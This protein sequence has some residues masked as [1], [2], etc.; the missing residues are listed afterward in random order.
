MEEKKRPILDELYAQE[1]AIRT[2]I[3]YP[4]QDIMIFSHKM[5]IIILYFVFFLILYLYLIIQHH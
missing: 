2:F 3:C 4:Q 5:H 1:Y